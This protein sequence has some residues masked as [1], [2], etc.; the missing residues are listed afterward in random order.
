MDS[1]CRDILIVK[2][3]VG[4]LV[5]YVFLGYLNVNDTG[6]NKYIYESMDQGIAAIV[7]DACVIVM[8]NFNGHVGFL[9]N[10]R[11][12]MVERCCRSLRRGG[13]W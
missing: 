3:T 13:V 1:S 9:G 10:R 8:G 4:E 12:T 7:G 11:G 2:L 5:V 6:R